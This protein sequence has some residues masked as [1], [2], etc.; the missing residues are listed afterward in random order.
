MTHHMSEDG[1]NG[2]YDEL[3]VANNDN[4]PDDAE[5]E[6]RKTSKSRAGLQEMD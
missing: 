5:H 6:H 2:E 1:L 4:N 3:E